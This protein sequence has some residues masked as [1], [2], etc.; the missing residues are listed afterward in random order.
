VTVVGIDVSA[1]G[2]PSCGGIGTSLYQTLRALAELDLSDDIILYSGRSPVIPFSEKPLDLPWPVHRGSGVLARSNIVWMQS[3]VNRLLREDRVRVFWGPRHLLPFRAPPVASV[4]TVHDFWARRYPG[5]QAW[6]NRTVTRV[7]TD[8]VLRQASIVVAPSMACAREAEQFGGLAPGSVRVVPWGVDTAVFRPSAPA[9]ISATLSRLGVSRPYVLSLD[10]FNPRK[11]FGSVLTAVAGITRRGTAL[12][13]VGLGS[14]RRSAS[15]ARPAERAASLGLGEYVHLPGD[16]PRDDLVALYSGAVALAY[17]SVYEGF[18]MP[19]LEAMA[20]D[21]PVITS[22][23]ASLPEVAAG[24]AVLV[25]PAHPAQL[26]EAL[27]RLV[28]NESE[29]SRLVASG[30]DRVAQMTWQTTAS[31]MLEVFHD[32]EERHMRGRR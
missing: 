31:K 13:L 22:T 32:A 2:M 4:A 3:A 16:V 26:E 17:P 7:L 23:R 28:S 29:R 21:C 14:P 5:Q 15:H 8:R 25:D 27:N 9:A 30:R 6:L 1:L 24:S 18:G 20:C 19:V 11:C 10:V 12:Q